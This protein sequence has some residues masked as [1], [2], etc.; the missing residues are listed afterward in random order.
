MEAVQW[1]T[2]HASPTDGSND[3]CSLPVV[4]SRHAEER[5]K[6][7]GIS[8]LEIQLAISSDEVYSLTQDAKRLPGKT[9]TYAFIDRGN[10]LLVVTSASLVVLTAWK[11]VDEEQ[12][13][14]Y[15]GARSASPVSTEDVRR[16]RSEARAQHEQWA[17]RTALPSP[18]YEYQPLDCTPMAYSEVQDISQNSVGTSIRV[19]P[20]IPDTREYYAARV[21]GKCKPVP[22]GAHEDVPRKLEKF[23]AAVSDR[24]HLKKRD[25]KT[26]RLFVTATGTQLDPEHWEELRKTT[27][28]IDGKRLSTVHLSVVTGENV[29]FSPDVDEALRLEYRS[30]RAV[31]K[32]ARGVSERPTQVHGKGE[33]RAC[34]ECNCPFG[35]SAQQQAFYSRENVP[36][37][38]RCERCRQEI[39]AI[40]RTLTAEERVTEFFGAVGRAPEEDTEDVSPYY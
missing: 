28:E 26:L 35:L 29:S 9:T 25:R 19:V 31:R 12:L 39:R 16:I 6:E 18:Y 13:Q 37:P 33:M 27:L 23:K 4:L 24:L 10:L 38:R 36:I 3:I 2:D 21:K 15:I 1:Y 11:A 20:S 5:Q 17:K 7:R 30:S 8:Q 22:V 40:G 32:D 14:Q 34:V